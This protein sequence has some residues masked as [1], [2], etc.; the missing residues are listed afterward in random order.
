M[1]T[2]RVQ[3]KVKLSKC[4]IIHSSSIRGS[5]R[6]LPLSLPCL[7]TH[8]SLLPSP[9]V[10]LVVAVAPLHY[11]SLSLSLI[12]SFPLL[13]HSLSSITS[14]PLRRRRIEAMR[15]T[16]QRREEITRKVGDA[17]ERVTKE[18]RQVEEEEKIE[19]GNYKRWWWE[20]VAV[21]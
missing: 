12:L 3:P 17:T 13:N 8:Y 1:S 7:S 11:V 20:A 2:S 21:K 10:T 15:R 4:S 6:L 5:R 16:K 18:E 9:L 14:L 19:S